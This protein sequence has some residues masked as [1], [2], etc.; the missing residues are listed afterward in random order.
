M[1]RDRLFL[2]EP[3][4]EDPNRLGTGKR[5]WSPRMTAQRLA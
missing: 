4:F 2:I 3:D 1:S 5:S